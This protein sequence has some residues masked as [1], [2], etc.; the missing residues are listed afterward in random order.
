M[1]DIKS[2]IRSYLFKLS[3]VG[4]LCSFFWGAAIFYSIEYSSGTPDESTGR[5]AIINYKGRNRYVTQVQL[6]LIMGLPLAGLS[7]LALGSLIDS[8]L[9]DKSPSDVE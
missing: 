3:I 2:R 8:F 7:I 9:S 6:Y 1:S 4:A 5:T